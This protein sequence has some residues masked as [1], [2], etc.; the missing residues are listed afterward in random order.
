MVNR[1]LLSASRSPRLQRQAMENAVARRVAHR[2]VAGERLDEA[3][4]VAARLG[5]RGIGGIP[6]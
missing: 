6:T 2:F 4:E 1:L 5:D 3:V